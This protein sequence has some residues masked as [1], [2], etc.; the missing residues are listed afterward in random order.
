MGV[1]VVIAT[2]LSPHLRPDLFLA[3]TNNGCV[4]L[5]LDLCYSLSSFKVSV[6][7]LVHQH[8]ADGDVR[9]LHHFWPCPVQMGLGR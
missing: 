2:F 7:A 5:H 6:N 8:S 3:Y 1:V 4:E 9:H